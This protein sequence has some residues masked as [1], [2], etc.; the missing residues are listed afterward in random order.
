MKILKKNTNGITLVALVITIILLLILAGITISQLTGS[1]LFGKAKRAKI[2]SEYT[3]AKEIIKLELMSI[4]TAC[5]KEENNYN[6]IEIEKGMEK[7][8][9]IT[10]DNIYYSNT[11]KLKGELEL[12]I[13]RK[14]YLVGILVSVDQ[15]SQYK[16]LIGKSGDIEKAVQVEI[17]DTIESEKLKP[18]D[19]F[20]RDVIGIIPEKNNGNNPGPEDPDDPK[21]PE[22]SNEPYLEG[23]DKT[24][25]YYVSWILDDES[26]EYVPNEKKMSENVAPKNW[27]NYTAGVNQWANI[28]TIGGG[29]DCYWVW[30]PRYAYK[31]IYTDTNDKSKGG[32]IDVVFLKEKSNKDLN[33]NDVTSNTYVDSKGNTGAYIVHPAFTSS[34]NGGF[35]ELTGIWIAKFE[36]SSNSSLILENPSTDQLETDGGSSTDTELKVRVKPNVTSWRN[37]TVGNI[38]T[39]CKNLTTVGNSLEDTSNID[40]H[41]MKNTEWGAIAYLSNSV[42][43]KN[44][45][46]WNNPYYNSDKNNSI[47]T[48]L[49]GKGAND[50]DLST[51]TL[52]DTYKYNEVGGEKASTTGNVYGVYDMSGGAWEYVTGILGNYKSM[53]GNYNFNDSTT[54]PNK[55]FDWYTGNSDDGNINYNL[56]ATKYGD[57]VYETSNHGLSVTG[58]WETSCSYFPNSASPVFVRGGHATGGKSI[59]VFA[60]NWTNGGAFNHISF[61]PCLVNVINH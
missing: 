42:Y 6:I 10:I 17:P 36:A 22:I 54:F 12:D 14:E 25:A 8:N 16:F 34:G 49:C 11:A 21:I 50:K 31:I 35:G 58:S 13:N 59:G 53:D 45:E 7:P 18:I 55:Y 5:I 44:S 15:Y 19:E 4:Q 23:F 28:K 40:S 9:H 52:N 48:G 27:Y 56:N 61:R 57:A 1:G 41:M 38:F 2:I 33:G 47:I 37:I 3:T 46:V 30:I 39:V 20:E 26:K 51:K 24:K 32:T 43:G 29:N 60:F